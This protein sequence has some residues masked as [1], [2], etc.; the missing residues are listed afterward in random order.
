MT[1]TCEYE[2]ESQFPNFVDITVASL[3]LYNPEMDVVTQGERE[4]PDYCLYEVLGC[5]VS[6]TV[7]IL[8][9][10]SLP[11]HIEF[12]EYSNSVLG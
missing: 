1:C 11:V 5:D 8:L 12:L 10:Y 4:D 2:S 9:S 3:Y 6:S 7:N